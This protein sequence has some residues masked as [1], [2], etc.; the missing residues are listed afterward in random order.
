MV[1]NKRSYLR[2]LPV[3]LVNVN[4]PPWFAGRIGIVAFVV[5]GVD[6]V[7]VGVGAAGVVVV[8]GVVFVIPVPAP[9]VD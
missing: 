5:G 6:V 4:G 8:G 9:S 2:H 7:I 1:R 3:M